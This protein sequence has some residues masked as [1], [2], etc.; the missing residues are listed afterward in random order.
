[1]TTYYIAAATILFMTAI[2]FVAG[3][4]YGYRARRDHT[5]SDYEDR[6]SLEGMR[7]RASREANLNMRENFL[8]GGWGLAV[9]AGAYMI[10][11]AIWGPLR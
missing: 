4:I 3:W 5:A 11:L 10:Y 1:M 7:L 6:Y 8:R 9:V 2:C